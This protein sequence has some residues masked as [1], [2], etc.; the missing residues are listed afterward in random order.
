MAEHFGEHLMIDGYGCDRNHLS[1]KNKVG[2][3]IREIVLATG[4][5]QLSEILCYEVKGEVG[6]KDSGGVTG[7]VVVKE[8]H[9]AIHTFTNRE[10]ISIDIFTC[11]NGMD[12]EK[13]KKICE[14]E[15][16]IK[17]ADATL[18][19]RGLHFPEAD[20]L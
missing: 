16:G 13:I 20:L 17:S 8:S 3:V 5:N 1:D 9:I 4:M 10:Y 6:T 11:K 15:F 19:K 14:L 2:Q 7:I 12:V 18:V